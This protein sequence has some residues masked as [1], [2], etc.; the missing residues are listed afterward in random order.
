[1]SSKP[2]LPANKPGRLDVKLK[3]PPRRMFPFH[4]EGVT[5]NEKSKFYGKPWT[6]DII[7]V[8]MESVRKTFK[9]KRTRT[10][11]ARRNLQVWVN[12]L[13]P[14]L[15]NPVAW[16]L[17]RFYVDRKER[18]SKY[19]RKMGLH[20]RQIDG[21]HRIRALEALNFN[22][23]YIYLI[24]GIP[25]YSNRHRVGI[26]RNERPAISYHHKKFNR[27]QKCGKQVKYV[28]SKSGLK[29][30]YKCQHCGDAGSRIMVY[31]EPV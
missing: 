25:S 4:A 7:A 9:F 28:V 23:I 11:K 27:C 19:L 31:P 10:A 16:R 5:K 21:S 22:F 14:A 13:G 1:M 12:H 3:Y 2:S 26:R 6:C 15:F 29:Q 24:L 18:S 30:I 17:K 8:P 20:I